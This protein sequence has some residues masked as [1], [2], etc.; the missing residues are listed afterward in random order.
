MSAWIAMRP[1]GK[2]LGTV[3]AA[4]FCEA[5]SAAF[6]LYGPPIAVRDPLQYWTLAIAASAQDLRADKAE[7]ETRRA[8]GLT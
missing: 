5:A 3:D 8:M 6:L 2:V 4:D 1:E 7:A